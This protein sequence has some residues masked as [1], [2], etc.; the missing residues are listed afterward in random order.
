MLAVSLS[1]TQQPG[2]GQAQEAGTGGAPGGLVRHVTTLTDPITPEAGVHTQVVV[3]PGR[4]H[5]AAAEAQLGLRQRRAD[6]E[7]GGRAVGARSLVLTLG[8][9]PVST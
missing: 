5:G 7:A 6:R 4:A 3:T 1:V 8:T 2:L 9:I